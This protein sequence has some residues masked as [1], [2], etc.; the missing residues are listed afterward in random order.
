M[1]ETVKNFASAATFPAAEAVALL[2]YGSVDQD[3]SVSSLPTAPAV[4]ARTVRIRGTLV[5]IGAATTSITINCR[6]GQTVA[7]TQVQN[8]VVSAVVAVGSSVP[9]EFVDTA[10]LLP[11]LNYAITLTTGA[12]SGTYNITAEMEEVN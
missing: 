5:V 6:R 12:A 4:G 2:L 9:F 11:A 7:G 1:A 3:T 10:P 8:S